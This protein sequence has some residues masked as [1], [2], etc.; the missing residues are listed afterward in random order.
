[1]ATKS[2]EHPTHACQHCGATS[3][4]VET[5]IDDEF[6]WN[7]ATGSYEPN[8]FTGIFEH[9]GSERCAVCGREWT[10]L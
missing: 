6:C 10:G 5:L 1:M 7:E 8:K 2:L 4:L 3:K 9:T